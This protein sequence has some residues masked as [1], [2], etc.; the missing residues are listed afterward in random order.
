MKKELFFKLLNKKLKLRIGSDHHSYSWYIKQKEELENLN[1]DP[2]EEKE[3]FSIVNNSKYMDILVDSLENLRES[4]LYESY[5]HGILH[6]LRVC[7]YSFY[8]GNK[9]NVDERLMKLAIYAALYHDIGRVDDSRDDYHGGRS[10]MLLP[11]LRLDIDEEELKVLQVAIKCHSLHDR[12]FKN[13]IDG[14]KDIEK[15]RM[16]FNI[17]KDS[18]ALDRVRLVGAPYV[19]IDMIRLEENKKLGFQ[20]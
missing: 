15:C 11:R 14:I 8:L 10:A 17:L 3:F 20:S 9:Y 5:I 19:K 6:N 12:E 13:N 1:I 16:L 2:V 4:F 18:D 7:L